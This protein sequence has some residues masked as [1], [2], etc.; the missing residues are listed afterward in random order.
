[1]G[2]YENGIETKNDIL[3][4]CRA[5]FYAKGY[6]RTTFVD[7]CRA[8]GV[9]QS[10]IHYHFKSKEAILKIIYDETIQKNNL[11]IEKYCGPETLPFT[12]FLFG[13]ELYLYKLLHDPQYRRFNLDAGRILNSSSF[14]EYMNNLAKT[15][16]FHDKSFTGLTD[17]MRFDLMA[18]LAYDH[19]LLIYL[20]KN[21]AS[22]GFEQVKTRN[23][24]IYRRI[25]RISDEEFSTAQEQLAALEK[26]C[27]WAELDTSLSV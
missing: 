22:V 6:D 10:S 24:D 16:Y 13:G 20:D 1:M 12:K 4:A 18:G 23:A 25:M 9:N 14:D 21:I 26:K 5:L 27:A 11:A 3:N 2:H 7:I 8:A 15:L 19:V 17:E